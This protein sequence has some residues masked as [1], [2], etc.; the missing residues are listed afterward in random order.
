[1]DSPLE[2]LMPYQ[3]R[4]M[5]DNARFKL[6]LWGR[7]TGKSHACAGEAVTQAWSWPKTEWVVLS[8]G[9]RQALEFMRK[10][11]DWAIAWGFGVSNYC[12]LRETTESLVKSAEV[13]LPNGSRIIG[14]PA[15]PD[16]A[17]GYSANLILDEFAFHERP[18]DIWRAIYPS[19]SNPLK[20]VKKLRIVSTA[21]GKANKFYELWSK[22]NGYSKHRVTIHEAVA[23][24]LKIDAEELRRGLDDPEGWAQE[25]ECEF[26]DTVAVLLPYELIAKGESAEAS[27]Q[28]AT[29]YWNAHSGNPCVLGIDFGRKHDLTCAWTLENLGDSQLTREVLCLEKMS[30]PDQVEQLRPRLQKA[31]R[32][33]LDYTGAGI[34]LGDYLVREFGEYNPERHLFGRIELCTFSAPF[35]QEVFSKLRMALEAG[36]LRIPISRV[37]REDLHA[38]QRVTTATGQI[39]YRAARTEDGHSD[40]ATALALA[41]RAAGESAPRF[42]YRPVSTRADQARLGRAKGVLL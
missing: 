17:R 14:L 24:G 5:D 2:M 42:A 23:Q 25:Y 19:I 40:R 9:E 26:M 8:S 16:T 10:V 20:G 39:A 30:T 32:V 38:I 37:I 21:N 12:E 1:M 18:E 29:E 13:T 36:C 15:N 4:W 31:R 35:K 3:T 41:L 33:C 28:I 27:E 11:Q 22:E 6:G 7:Q 34:G